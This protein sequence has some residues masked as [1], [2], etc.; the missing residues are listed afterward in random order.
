MRVALAL[1]ALAG[2][3]DGATADRGLTAMLQ[4]EGAQFRPGGFPADA[5]GPAALAVAAGTSQIVIDRLGD[6]LDGT[7]EPAARGVAIGIAG[8]DGAWLIRAG[9]PDLDTPGLP[10]AKATFGL[11]AGFPPGPFELQIAASD[12][13]GRFGAPARAML[14]A[15][16]G[17]TPA[18]EL[19]IALT[20]EGAADLDLH[21]VDA[22]GGEAWS[23]DPNTFDPPPGTTPAPEDYLRHGILDRDANADCARDGRPAEHVVW[24]Q[25]PPA[26]SYVIRVD[27]RAMCGEAIAHW[28][29]AAYLRSGGT[30]DDAD[31]LIGAARGVASAPDTLQPHGRGA[32]ILALRFD[33]P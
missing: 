28:N 25:P 29:V 4:V 2:C 31:V 18:G 10:S 27:A 22:L 9:L 33:L 13:A 24:S 3:T 5:G 1:L 23:D 8:E 14:M 6:R 11:A 17:P 26:G 21:V 30:G 16:A 7:L 19:V 32:G 15:N 20:W 12:D